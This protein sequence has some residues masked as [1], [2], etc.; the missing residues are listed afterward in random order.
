MFY[1][2]DG[3]EKFAVVGLHASAAADDLLKLAN[4][5]DDLVK[6]D[7]FAGLCVHAGGHQF[8]SDGNYRIFALQIDE[9]IKLFFTFHCV[10]A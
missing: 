9:I 3:E 5:V 1:L 8:G 7:N 10:M 6:H 4:G 2:L